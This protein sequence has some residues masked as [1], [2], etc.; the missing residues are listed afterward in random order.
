MLPARNHVPLNRI[1]SASF[2]IAWL[3]NI[4]LHMEL[5]R[6]K[7]KLAQ[8]CALTFDF[9]NKKNKSSITSM[10]CRRCS[11]RN[12]HQRVSIQCNVMTMP[13]SPI[14]MPSRILFKVARSTFEPCAQ[15][16]QFQLPAAG[17]YASHSLAC[18]PVCAFR[19][20]ALR[21]A[22]PFASNDIVCFIV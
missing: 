4:D 18:A 3:R 16:L 1:R 17:C 21:F 14:E 10:H 2:A 7:R 9:V 13:P 20:R 19:S 12:A 22:A 8:M 11:L 6:G 15:E 5:I